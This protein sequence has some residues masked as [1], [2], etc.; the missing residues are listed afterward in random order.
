MFDEATE[1]MVSKL[2]KQD[3]VEKVLVQVEEI[4]E[5]EEPRPKTQR[6]VFPR[7]R[8][9]VAKRRPFFF[10]TNTSN[11]LWLDPTT[12]FLKR[13]GETRAVLKAP[14]NSH[15][16]LVAADAL[17]PTPAARSTLPTSASAGRRSPWTPPA[18]GA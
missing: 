18:A 10:P 5:K 2:E 3:L 12:N 13:M 4:P 7:T 6:S 16:I 14:S 11:F 8:K 9:R 1:L 15:L 17:H